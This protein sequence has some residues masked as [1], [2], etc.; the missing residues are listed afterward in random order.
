MPVSVELDV[1]VQPMEAIAGPT[2]KI[3]AV[4]RK[5]VWHVPT[6]DTTMPASIEAMMCQAKTS[7]VTDTDANPK[8]TTETATEPTDSEGSDADVGRDLVENWSTIPSRRLRPFAPAA[9]QS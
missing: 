9:R 7:V 6:R 2:V 4:E 8:I 5:I 1:L 3:E